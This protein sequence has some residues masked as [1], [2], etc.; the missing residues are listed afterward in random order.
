MKM[1]SK[2]LNDKIDEICDNSELY[3]CFGGKSIPYIGWFWRNVNFDTK[4]HTFGIMDIENEDDEP[5]SSIRIV[6][7]MENN[8]WDYDE[9]VCPEE[10]WE[11]IKDL[12]EWAVENPSYESLK[13]VNDAVQSILNV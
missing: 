6:G 12:L 9:K 2:E 11:E 10:L 4:T 13:S 1:T 8:K 3:E 5:S 7:F